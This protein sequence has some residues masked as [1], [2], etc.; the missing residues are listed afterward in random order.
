M[1][2]LSFQSYRHYFCH[3]GNDT[4]SSWNVRVLRQLFIISSHL[5]TMLSG[6]KYKIF[7]KNLL[8]IVF[9]VAVWSESLVNSFKLESITFINNT[10]H[11]NEQFLS[12][13]VSVP[14]WNEIKEHWRK[15]SSWTISVIR[16]TCICLN[17]FFKLIGNI[18]RVYL[19]Y[20]R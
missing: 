10:D 7:I 2:H 16:I 15:K 6:E 12:Y 1:L 19:P 14:Y 11:A 20:H 17:S 4:L 8:N 18:F 5:I 9:K 3:I 13:E